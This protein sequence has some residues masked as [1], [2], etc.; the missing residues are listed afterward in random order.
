MAW[1]DACSTTDIDAEDV[2]RFDHGGRTFAIYRNHEDGYFCTDGLCTHED[3]H[4]ADGMVIENTVECPKHS[5]IFNFTNGE[6]ETPPACDNLH[7]YAA[8]VEAGRVLISI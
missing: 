8:R 4:L 1:I 5:S 7:C 2:I 3:I 6:V